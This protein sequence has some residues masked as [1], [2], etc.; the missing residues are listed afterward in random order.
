[1]LTTTM[2]K[3]KA[4]FFRIRKQVEEIFLVAEKWFCKKNTMVIYS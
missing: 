2:K 1:M 4:H 3:H